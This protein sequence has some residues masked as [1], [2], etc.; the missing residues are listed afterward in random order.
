MTADHLLSV[1]LRRSD[2]ERGHL[3]SFALDYESASK[4]RKSPT[5][6]A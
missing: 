1:N 5:L 6:R 2:V 3:L 4:H